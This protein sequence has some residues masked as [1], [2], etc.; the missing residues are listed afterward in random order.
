ML[1]RT[2]A[3]AFTDTQ[4]GSNLFGLRRLEEVLEVTV[5][6]ENIV[7]RLINNII[8][9]CVHESGVLIDLRGGGLIEPNRSTDVAALVESQVV[10]CWFSFIGSEIKQSFCGQRVRKLATIFVTFSVLGC[11]MLHLEHRLDQKAFRIAVVSTKRQYFPKDAATRL[12]FNMDDKING[13]SDLGFG[14]GEGGWRVVAHNQI[15]E[16]PEGLLRRVGVNR[17][18]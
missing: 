10:A 15:G 11:R 4:S 12:S 14:V 5:L 2:I 6:R 13:F 17:C 8:G 16:A 3:H 1:R 7:E 18:Q 9:G